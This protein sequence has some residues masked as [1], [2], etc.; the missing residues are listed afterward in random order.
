VLATQRTGAGLEQY[1]SPV[2]PPQDSDCRG[3][4][5]EQQN[6]GDKLNAK[7]KCWWEMARKP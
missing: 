6:A 4:V 5:S 1:I 7:D 3:S 2:L